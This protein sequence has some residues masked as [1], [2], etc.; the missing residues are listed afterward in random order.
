MLKAQRPCQES[1]PA[2]MHEREKAKLVRHHAKRPLGADERLIA[3][4][5]EQIKTTGLLLPAEEQAVNPP[6]PAWR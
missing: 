2:E 6:P 3:A 1:D 5:E 4:R